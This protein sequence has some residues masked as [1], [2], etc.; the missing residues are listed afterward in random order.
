MVGELEKNAIKLL[1]ETEGILVDPVYTGRAFGALVDMI[2]QGEFNLND[3]V[4]FWHTGGAPSIFS[5]AEKIL[6]SQ[7]VEYQNR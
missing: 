2:R 7:T 1:A 5:Y 4:L 6:L 3:T